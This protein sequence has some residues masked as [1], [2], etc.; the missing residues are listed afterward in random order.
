MPF[1]THT[2]RHQCWVNDRAVSPSYCN[3]YASALSRV[4][5]VADLFKQ[6]SPQKTFWRQIFCSRCPCWWPW[7]PIRSFR[8]ADFSVLKCNQERRSAI[9]SILKRNPSGRYR[10]FAGKIPICLA[11]NRRKKRFEGKTFAL[12]APVDGL[13]CSSWALEWFIFLFLSAIGR[14]GFRFESHEFTYLR[15]QM[16]I[17]SHRLRDCRRKIACFLLIFRLFSCWYAV[18]SASRQPIEAE[19]NDLLSQV[20]WAKGA[21]VKPTFPHEW[22]GLRKDASQPTWLCV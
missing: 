13:D 3:I 17:E 2:T 1:T 21:I 16:P 15:R 4:K 18:L 11:K 19:I 5:W 6:K 9:W 14:S 22:V 20:A 8:F 12:A 7:L 10:N